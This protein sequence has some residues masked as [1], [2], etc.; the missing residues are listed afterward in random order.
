MLYV[1]CN[2]RIFD[3]EKSATAFGLGS[4][5]ARMILSGAPLVSTLSQ[6]YPMIVFTVCT[7]LS[8]LVSCLVKVHP[9]LDRKQAKNQ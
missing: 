7:T 3:V 8:A 6:P 9:T 4:F 1:A 5:F 2:A